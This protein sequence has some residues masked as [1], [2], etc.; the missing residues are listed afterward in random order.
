MIN[1][2]ELYNFE[3]V[4]DLELNYTSKLNQWLIQNE[5]YNE[6]KFL[7]EAILFNEKS[8]SHLTILS[9][10]EEEYSINNAE[11]ILKSYQLSVRNINKPLDFQ[12]SR[13]DTDSTKSLI[14]YLYELYGLVGRYLKKIKTEDA[15]V[16]KVN[17]K[18]ILKEY[19]KEI[20]VD[21]I[22]VDDYINDF[23]NENFY[24]TSFLKK[25]NSNNWENDIEK[26]SFFDFNK[27]HEHLYHK[28]EVVKILK[29]KFK[30]KKSFN[31]LKF[32]SKVDS[33]FALK[34]YMLEK[35]GIIDQLKVNYQIEDSK[36][37]DFIADLLGCTNRTVR[38]SYLVK[39]VSPSY[40]RIAE[41]Y[42][43]N[44]NSLMRKE[45]EGTP[46]KKFGLFLKNKK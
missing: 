45:M 1:K 32:D 14:S 36:I 25:Y 22:L 8:I 10:L 40:K 4:S 30:T 9:E 26:Y 44:L 46:R 18:N 23:L 5:D 16:T 43:E 31:N 13:K 2:E 39:S 27:F 12:I 6:R 38:K 7:K 11:A 15:A 17:I 29:K 20:F 35:M 24:F 28:N 42:I 21:Y 37:E 33:D 41:S 34:I 3:D 19:T